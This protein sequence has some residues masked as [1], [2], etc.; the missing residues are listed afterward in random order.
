MTG[1]AT[2]SYQNTKPSPGVDVDCSTNLDAALLGFTITPPKTP[3]TAVFSAY[4]HPSSEGGVSPSGSEF[5]MLDAY[6]T[7]AASSTVNVTVGKFLSYLG[8]ESFLSESG[9]H[10]LAGQPGSSCR[11]DSRLPRG[12]R[13]STS[14]WIRPT[15]SGSVVTDS[16]YQKPGYAATEGDGEFRHSAGF[17]GYYTNTA[18]TNL[19]FIWAGIGYDT[20][21]TKPGLRRHRRGGENPAGHDVWVA[22]VWASYVLDKNNDKLVGEE[23][24]KDGGSRGN[25]G[26][27]TGSLY[28]QYNF[29]SQDLRLVLRE[30]RGRHQRTELH[31]VQRQ[32]HLQP[33]RQRARGAPLSIPTSSTK[34]SRP[35]PPTTAPRK[36]P[37]LLERNFFGAQVI[38]SF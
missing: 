25:K 24:Y 3:V 22:D 32:P 30:R 15:P 14:P 21:K 29:D 34:I 11:A 1:W 7:Y 35:S 17:E 13:R 5:T 33:D 4:Y 28:Y 8:Y 9:Q 31:Q 38:F 2:G 16:E 10:D 23:I 18:V 36:D 12:A 20:L 27:P 26:F 37:E 6:I 19:T